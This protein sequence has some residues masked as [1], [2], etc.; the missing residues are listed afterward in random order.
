LTWSFLLCTRR[1]NEASR[2]LQINL[3]DHV[4]I[5]MPAPGRRSYFSLKAGGVIS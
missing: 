5:G 4:I 3:L 1:I 2:I